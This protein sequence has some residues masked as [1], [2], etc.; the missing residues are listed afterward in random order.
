MMKRIGQ[1]LLSPE[2][3]LWDSFLAFLFSGFWFI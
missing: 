1:Q 2:K 3:K